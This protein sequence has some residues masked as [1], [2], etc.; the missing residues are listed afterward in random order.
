MVLE[1]YVLLKIPYESYNT[2]VIGDIH[3]EFNLLKYKIKESGIKDSL[4]I[5][6]G[7]C[8]FG[9]ETPKH[10]EGVYNSMK[11][12][13]SDR[14]VT[15]VFVKGN[16]DSPS[17]F[18]GE[19]KIDY[20]LFKTVQ[21]YT[22]IN[23]LDNANILCVGGAISVDRKDR[24]RYDVQRG[25]DKTSNRRTYW[26]DEAP[27]YYPNIIDKIKSDGIEINHVVTHTS[28]H[29]APLTDKNGISNFLFEDRSLGKDVDEE[30]LT[31]TFIYNHLTK[32][33]NFKIENWIY[34]H[35]HQHQTYY[36]EDNVKFIML[37]CM[38]GRNNSWDIT[39]VKNC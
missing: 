22:V 3:G 37:D 32:R 6:A 26:E 5:V 15:I 10:Y 33:C 38:I 2:Y 35:F 7:D 4:I 16:H 27:V 13:L 39:P 36:N 8:G 1:T 11:R 18:N 14:N 9:F 29:F 34:G 24:I 30:R 25:W 17:Y 19:N 12:V 31:M 23:T 28:P 21:D 20:K